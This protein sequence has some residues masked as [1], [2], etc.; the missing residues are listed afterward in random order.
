MTDIKEITKQ[1][2]QGVKDVF[3]S[4]KYLEYLKFMARFHHYSINNSLLIWIQNPAASLVAGYRTWMTKFNRNVRKG[5]KGI[6]ILAPCPHKFMKQ[7]M[8]KDGEVEEIEVKY[9]SFKPTTVFDI[10]QT[11]GDDVPGLCEELT[12]DVNGY[13]ELMKKLEAVSPVPVSFEDITSGALGY[14]Q[15]EDKRI[16]I[17]TGMSQMQT[18]KTLVHEI[19]HA[20]LHEKENG[21]EKDAD[22]GTKEVQAESVAYTVCTMLGLDTAEYSF[23]YV[24]GWSAGREVKELVASME[25][26]RRTAEDIYNEVLA[27]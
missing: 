2:E 20:I 4:E 18:V 13:D 27:A 15:I 19:S 6:T 9:T 14:Y 3:D 8:N 1:L 23:E 12:G 7:Q 25:V 21:E 26:I 24:A 17:K 5:E 22:R 16:V 11:D 10:S